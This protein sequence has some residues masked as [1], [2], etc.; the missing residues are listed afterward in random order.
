M[1]ARN[2]ARRVRWNVNTDELVEELEAFDPQYRTRYRT[3]RDAAEA[4]GIRDEFEDW[5]QTDD[6]QRY[7]DAARAHDH[8]AD[9]EARRAELEANLRM[10]SRGRKQQSR[11]YVRDGDET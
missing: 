9:N 6:G 5:L 11:G 1:L 2:A 10:A 4:A 7:L 8:R 3:L